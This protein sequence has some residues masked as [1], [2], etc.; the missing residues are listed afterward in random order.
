[1]YKTNYRTNLLIFQGGT[2]WRGAVISKILLFFGG[3]ALIRE[4][5]LLQ[6]ERLLDH[7]RYFDRKIFTVQLQFKVV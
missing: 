2:Y 6:S 1:M 3:G 7:L 4:G 5:R